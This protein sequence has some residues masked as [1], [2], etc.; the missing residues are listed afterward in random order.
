MLKNPV[1]LPYGVTLLFPKF[2]PLQY[3]LADFPLSLETCANNVKPFDMLD[4]KII[5]GKIDHSNC[6][7]NAILIRGIAM[8]S[9][10]EWKTSLICVGEMTSYL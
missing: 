6:W 8:M 4:K 2:H 7:G 3:F 9:A 10:G 1:Q 5:W